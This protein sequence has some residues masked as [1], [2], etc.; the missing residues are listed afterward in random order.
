MDI[1][2]AI[3][4]WMDIFLKGVGFFVKNRQDLKKI[5]LRSCNNCLTKKF[6]IIYFLSL[7]GKIWLRESR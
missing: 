4:N 2:R 7:Y 5:I 1:F 6:T 3:E